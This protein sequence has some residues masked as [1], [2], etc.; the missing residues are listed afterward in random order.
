MFSW[1]AVGNTLL[2]GIN[3]ATYCAVPSATPV[4]LCAAVLLVW[5]YWCCFD[6]RVQH[7][8]IFSFMEG[9]MHL[10]ILLMKSNARIA[11]IGRF[12]FPSPLCNLS[13]INDVLI[14]ASTC[15]SSIP[16]NIF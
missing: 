11:A 4:S 14:F 2:Q 8:N 16:L 9:N 13:D 3:S 6:D 12:L 1:E 7:M 15:G 5:C 10:N